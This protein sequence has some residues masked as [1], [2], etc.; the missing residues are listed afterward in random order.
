MSSISCE[1]SF[2]FFIRLC[3][4]DYLLYTYTRRKQ[5]L[6]CFISWCLAH[7]SVYLQRVT[8]E[9]NS[10]GL[11][12]TIYILHT[13]LV[14]SSCSERRKWRQ[15]V[16]IFYLLLKDHQISIHSF[17]FH[18]EWEQKCPPQTE[19]VEDE[20]QQLQGWKKLGWPQFLHPP[21]P[22]AY[23]LRLFMSSLPGHSS[24]SRSNLFTAYLLGFPDSSY[25]L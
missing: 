17:C 6:S 16:A 8:V 21:S 3:Y 5:I 24:P 22:L 15:A 2:S 13:Q 19:K 11:V 23:Q 18:F 12:L 25:R 4:Y 14:L 7:S 9:L 10:Q 1:S 20:G